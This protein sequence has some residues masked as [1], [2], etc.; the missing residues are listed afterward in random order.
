MYQGY[1]G[2][3]HGSVRKYIGASGGLISPVLH[4][5]KARK[6]CCGQIFC[7]CPFPDGALMIVSR[8][9]TRRPAVWELLRN[10]L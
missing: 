6:N 1:A 7:T 10:T 5:A 9:A 8:T 4:P 3:A 2:K